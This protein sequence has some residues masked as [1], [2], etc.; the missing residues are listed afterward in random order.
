M[1]YV[2]TMKTIGLNTLICVEPYNDR[3]TRTM[4]INLVS[5][6]AHKVQTKAETCTALHHMNYSHK[7][8]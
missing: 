7:I 5:E 1:G 3:F 4:I 6:E 2:V 8:I